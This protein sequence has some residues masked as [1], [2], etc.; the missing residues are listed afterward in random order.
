[1]DEE[2]L[3]SVDAELMRDESYAR[4]VSNSAMSVSTRPTSPGSAAG[5]SQ[6]QHKG[7]LDGH[8]QALTVYARNDR[9]GPLA[10]VQGGKSSTADPGR[11]EQK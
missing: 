6:E 2:I 5:N 1:M 3:A 9:V 11:A 8:C 4:F 10:I 7:E